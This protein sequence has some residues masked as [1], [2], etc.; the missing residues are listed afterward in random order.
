MTGPGMVGWPATLAD[1]RARAAIDARR[2]GVPPTMIEA[3]ARRRAAGDWRGA[4]AA[5]DVEVSF[6]PDAVR[7]RHGRAA[8]DALLADLRT[9]APDLLRWHL[10]RCGHGAGRL[11]DGLLIPLA[12]YAGAGTVLTLAAATPGFALAAGERI[13]L[14]LL[15]SEAV[16]GGRAEA[17]AGPALREL[18]NSVHRRSAE[19]YSL[20]RQRMFW[21]AACAPRLRALCS[22]D[23]ADGALGA[24]GADEILRLQDAGRAVDAWT[25]AGFAVTVGTSPAA[26]TVTAD[27]RSRLTRWLATV[28]VNLPRL[29][30]RVRD[31]LPGTRRA[32]IRCGGGAIILSGLDDDARPRAEVVPPRAVRALTA[33]PPPVPDAAWARP[34]DADLLRLGLLEAH[35]LHPLVGSALRET[36]DEP[37]ASD[38][39][40]YS[41]VLG[42]EAQYAAATGTGTGTGTGAGA[43]DRSVVL[44]RCGADLHRVARSEGRWLA[45]DHEDHAVRELLLARLGGPT[46]PCRAAAEHLGSG[47]H[48]IELVERLLDHGR[49]EEATR[50]LREHADAL[51]APER[52]AL[53]D[54]RTV[55]QVLDALR[56]NTLRLRMTLA[57]APPVRDSVSYR[58]DPFRTRVRRSRKGDPA[59]PTLHR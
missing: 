19:R 22:A 42:I 18:L 14:T 7:R 30:E 52:F 43:G 25:A 20:R 46:N 3:A 27:E 58:T 11:L 34:L 53:P 41:S 1:A 40:R 4:C 26:G 55:G 48:V 51:V 15:E 2:H 17:N 54:G 37:A 35:E 38:E 49:V 36:P 5:A 16:R 31:A 29:T 13:V 59:R 24:G 45:V 28:P 8:A 39:W 47:R 10:P 6:H 56:E 21:D 12:D 50:L 32:L 9:L 44:V 23:G 57:G 33:S